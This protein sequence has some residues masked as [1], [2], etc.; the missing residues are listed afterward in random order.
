MSPGPP[1]R[2]RMNDVR[3]E[4]VGLVAP[5]LGADNHHF[6]GKVVMCK[7]DTIQYNAVLTFFVA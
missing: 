5:T 1:R 2:G 3:D 7:L 6:G 4:G